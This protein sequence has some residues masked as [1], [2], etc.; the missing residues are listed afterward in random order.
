MLFSTAILFTITVGNPIPAQL[1]VSL[2]GYDRFFSFSVEEAT[3]ANIALGPKRMTPNSLIYGTQYQLEALKLPTRG[4]TTTV[5]GRPGD[6]S[7]LSLSAIYEYPD[8][9]ENSPLSSWVPDHTKGLPNAVIDSI[10]QNTVKE[11]LDLDNKIR[12]LVPKFSLNVDYGYLLKPNGWTEIEYGYDTYQ[13]RLK[14]TVK[15]SFSFKNADDVTNN[16]G[17]FQYNLGTF[18]VPD[19]NPRRSR[20]YPD[21][22]TGDDHPAN[23][24]G[25]AIIQGPED[26]EPL[27]RLTLPIFSYRFGDQVKPVNAQDYTN[28]VIQNFGIK[29][30]EDFMGRTPYKLPDV[31]RM[32]N[33][34]AA[35]GDDMS[36]LFFPGSPE[37]IPPCQ[38]QVMF[39]QNT[40]WVPDRPG[41]QT[42][43]NIQ[44]HSMRFSFLVIGND[45]FE[46]TPQKMRTLCMNF[47]LKQ[48]EKGVRYFPFFRND[49]IAR[50]LAALTE[51]SAFKGPWD[52]ARMWIYTD[53]T[54][55]SEI[56][57]RMFPGVSPGRYI[58]GLY[59]VMR[60]GGLESKDLKDA[61]LFDTSL[62]LGAGASNKSLAWFI[63]NMIQNF[64]KQTRSFLESGSAD[65]AKMLA[66]DAKDFEKKYV[67]QLMRLLLNQS[68]A[69]VRIGALTFLNRLQTGAEFLKGQIGDLFYS[70]ISQDPKEIELTKMVLQKY[71]K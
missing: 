14:Y 47:E 70:R 23:L 54:P 11:D 40:F 13:I 31:H 64:P 9:P 38:S 28:R 43:T 4:E 22:S 49:P 7:K 36:N 52:Q 21:N 24:I 16:Y 39:P 56:N 32:L 67:P 55:L 5:I 46:I 27:T 42:M 71:Q 6:P 68:N 57:K 63:H 48:P 1:E 20:F 62:L 35:Q 58:D 69:E 37:D 66:P 41:Y 33:G 2:S 45:A 8:I 17:P 51:R 25:G 10:L 53:K 3:L 34:A 44:N 12:E 29:N 18:T 61:K 19:S 30:F 26:D 15:E 50:N 59:D 65:L 60:F